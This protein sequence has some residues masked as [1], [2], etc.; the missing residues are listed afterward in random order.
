MA[1][2]RIRL[3]SV[4]ALLVVAGTIGLWGYLFLIADPGIPDELEDPRFPA[5]AQAVCAEAVGRID[6]L[7]AASDATSPE[8]RGEAVAEANG[9]LAAMVAELRAIAPADGDDGRLIRLWLDDWDTYLADRVDY[10]ERLA[11]GEDAELL[12]TARGSGQITITLDNFTVV[13][14]MDDCAS[15]LDA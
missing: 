2:S 5:E 13:N 15:P 1:P 11:D 6:D 14:D 10:A 7:P 12:V 8:E 9:I 4:L 3:G